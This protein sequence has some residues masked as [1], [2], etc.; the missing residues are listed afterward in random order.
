MTRCEQKPN[1][2]RHK[3]N[4]SLCCHAKVAEIESDFISWRSP[5]AIAQEYGLA[6]RTSVYRH[7]TCSRAVPQ[8]N[9]RGL[10]HSRAHE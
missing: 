3:R 5:A 1:L 7:A 6:D 2:G 4:C 8:R 9:V 10:N